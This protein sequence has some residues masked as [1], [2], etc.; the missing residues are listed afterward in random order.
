VEIRVANK[1]GAML[2]GMYATA[3]IPTATANGPIVPREAVFDRNGGRAV[4][5]VQGDTV[6]IV[7]VTE[8]LSDG[9][10]VVLVSGVQA[11][12]TIVSDARREVVQGS[13][14]RVIQSH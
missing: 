1:G 9:K 8:G 14:V 13:R 2:S 3:R 10:R 12:D 5:R 11:G 4:Y 7:A 6:S